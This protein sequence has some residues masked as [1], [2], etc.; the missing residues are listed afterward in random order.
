MRIKSLELN[1]FKSFVDKTRIAFKPGIT[2]VVGPNGCGKSNV[3]DAMRW[4][5]GEQSPRRLRGKG[6]DDVIFAGSEGRSPVGMAEV[7]L[8]FDNSD[9]DA[10][11]AFSAYTEI[12]VARRLYRSGES[13]YLLNR[14]PCR[15]RDV[16]DFFR[17]SG[18][19]TKGY[20]IVEQGRIAEIVSAKPEERRILI[21]EAAGISKYK[22]RRREAESKLRSTEQNLLRVTDVIAE[23]R[24]QIS[25][26]ER[27]A[28][29]ATRYKRLRETRRVLDLSLAADERSE[30]L[31]E[32]EGSRRRH[33]T[34]CDE[35]TGLEAKLAEREASVAQKR[36]EL[37]ECERVLSGGSEAL[38]ALR[39]EI[40]EAEGRIE[41]GRREREALAETI[42]APVHAFNET[43]H[44][45]LPPKHTGIIGS[46]KS[47]V[48]VFTQPGSKA[49][50][51]GRS[52]PAAPPG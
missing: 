20:T 26:I 36:I 37:A 9:G 13:E 10:P 16:Q 34:L 45:T 8:T 38:L 2:A 11:P 33:R 35:V 29:K 27:Q 25:S 43:L 1:G 52:K 3:V 22:A 15:L 48:D 46:K 40:K 12:Q 6:M 19:G 49:E 14:T 47:A 30:L 17:D 18:V 51:I 24:R 31:A 4:A 21:E 50:V 32:I 41:Y 23:I 5:M 39:N 28:R 7:I 42:A 44:D